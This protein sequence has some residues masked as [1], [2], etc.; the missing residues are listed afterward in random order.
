MR[1]YSID[2]DKAGSSNRN[3]VYT[4]LNPMITGES[5]VKIGGHGVEKSTARPSQNRSRPAKI[6]Q[7][8]W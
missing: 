2:N 7:V 5:A 3:H 6:I 8:Q 4:K 1:I